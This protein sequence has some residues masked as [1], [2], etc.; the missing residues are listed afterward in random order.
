MKRR[1]P[2]WFKQSLPDENVADILKLIKE[3]KLN[4]ICISGHCPN[5]NKCFKNKT[6]TF[7]ILGD[8]C[9]RDCKFC[10]VKKGS[11]YYSEEKLEDEPKK[12][13]EAVERLGLDFVVITSVSRDDLI[14]KGASH[15]LKVVEAIRSIGSNIKIELLIPD[16]LGD[17]ILLKKVIESKPDVIAHNLEIP[18]PLYKKIKPQSNYRR[19]LSVLSMIKEIKPTIIT[20]SSLILGLGET[21]QDVFRTV[22]DLANV[23]VDILTLGQYLSPSQ[24]HYP[25]KEFLSLEKFAFYREVALKKGIKVVASGPLVRSSFESKQ[26]YQQFLS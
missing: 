1:L 4:T 12:I 9:S 19:S 7:L 8:I 17:R 3:L 10:A 26:L 22:E 15:F 20:K 2:F 13:K 21:E 24:D 16:F 23:N 14:D 11:F 5:I 6:L 18:E 25:V